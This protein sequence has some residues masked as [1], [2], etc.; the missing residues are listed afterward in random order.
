MVEFGLPRAKEWYER[1]G[2]VRQKAIEDGEN[3]LVCGGSRPKVGKT[4]RIYLRI[5]RK[6]MVK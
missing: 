6:A 4:T 2:G 5:I 1:E 3:Q